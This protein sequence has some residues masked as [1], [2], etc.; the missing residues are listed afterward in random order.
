MEK[1]CSFLCFVTG[2]I[3]LVLAIVSF[4]YHIF[5]MGICYAAGLMVLED[6]SND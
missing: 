1:I 6:K 3:F 4:W 5:T 2:T